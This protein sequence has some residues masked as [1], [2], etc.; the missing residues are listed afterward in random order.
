M[1][2]EPESER[3]C[4]TCRRKKP[5]NTAN[6]KQVRDKGIGTVTFAVSCLQCSQRQAES[7]KKRLAKKRGK[8]D[9]NKENEMPVPA[10]GIQGKEKDGN[11]VQAAGTIIDAEEESAARDAEEFQV[12]SLIDIK[13]LTDVLEQREEHTISLMA[14]IDITSLELGLEM[15]ERQRADAIRKHIVKSWN[16]QFK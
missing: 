10:E 11:P 4:T 16:Y 6:F 9:E 2:E 8:E 15:T 14:R 7:R 5:L 3:F 12:L 1:V 13:E